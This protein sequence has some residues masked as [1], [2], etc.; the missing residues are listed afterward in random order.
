MQ[1]RKKSKLF[2]TDAGVEVSRFEFSW[3]E[4]FLYSGMFEFGCG[5]T[6]GVNKVMF[7]KS[8]EMFQEKQKHCV[9]VSA[10]QITPE[11]LLGWSK[12]E[13]SEPTV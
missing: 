11:K 13:W 6:F 3:A 2:T 10:K 1:L 9:D 8:F 5:D 7:W 12:G 4:S